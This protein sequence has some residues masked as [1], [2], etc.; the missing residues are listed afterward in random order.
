MNTHAHVRTNTADAFTVD[1]ETNGRQ[2]QKKNNKNKA[3][4]AT[5]A[6]EQ[7]RVVQR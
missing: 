5:I 4:R 3:I 6:S 7:H 1:A 2:N